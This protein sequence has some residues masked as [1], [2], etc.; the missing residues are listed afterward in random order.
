MSFDIKYNSGYIAFSN[1]D[2]QGKIDVIKVDGGN[3]SVLE[4]YDNISDGLSNS[5]DLK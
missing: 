2:D 4:T 5:L 1:L 3:I